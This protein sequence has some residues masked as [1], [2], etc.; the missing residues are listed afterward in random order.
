MTCVTGKTPALA[1]ST[2]GIARDDPV[3]GIGQ[4]IKR[5]FF[6]LSMVIWEKRAWSMV[7]AS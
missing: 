4:E 2:A 7:K 1:H 5:I 6:V 3:A